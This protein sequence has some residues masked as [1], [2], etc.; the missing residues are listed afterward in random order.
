M[1][2]TESRLHHVETRRETYKYLVYAMFLADN[3]GHVRLIPF[4]IDKNYPQAAIIVDEETGRGWVLAIIC[5]R[6]RA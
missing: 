5:E 6:I 2:F 3:L 1:D 4:S